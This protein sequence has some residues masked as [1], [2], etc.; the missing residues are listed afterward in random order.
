MA[1][2]R[3]SQTRN[4]SGT[5]LNIDGQLAGDSVRVIEECCSQALAAGGPVCL[6]LRDVSAIDDAGHALLRRLAG[7]GVRLQASGV[8]TSH[9]IKTL[10][11]GK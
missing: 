8:Y 5:V 7:Q 2:F 1:I 3:V 11:L 9:L 4:R 10:R 6:F